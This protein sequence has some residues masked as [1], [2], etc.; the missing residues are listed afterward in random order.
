MPLCA[1]GSNA[2]KKVV[3]SVGKFMFFEDDKSVVMSMD[4]VC[5]A[6]NQM[7]FISEVVKLVIHAEEYDVNIHELGLRNINM[8]HLS[9]NNS[10]S[11]SKVDAESNNEEDYEIKVIFVI[12]FRKDKQRQH[13]MIST[14]WK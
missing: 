7:K 12:F 4:R 8:D 9:S 11:D 2:F 3:A 14:I 13:K 6:T 5:I 10:Y 1:W